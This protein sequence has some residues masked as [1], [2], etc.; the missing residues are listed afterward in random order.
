MI[1]VTGGAGFIGANLVKKLNQRGREDIIVV[2][3]MS[4]VNKVHNLADCTITDFLNKE[5]FLYFAGGARGQERIDVVFHQGACSDTMATDGHYVMQNN[6]SYSKAVLNFCQQHRIPLVYASSASVYGANQC[7]TEQKENEAPLNAYALSKLWFDQHLRTRLSQLTAP[8]MGLRYFNVY[9]YRE[10]HKGSMASVAH[11]FYQQFQRHQKVK[12]FKGSGGYDNGEQRRD[13]VFIDDVVDVNLHFWEHP[14][15]GI[16]NVG[17][18]QAHSFNDVAKAVVNHCVADNEM[19]LE[20]MHQQGLIEYVDFPQAL[21]GKY[22][23]Y[24]CADIKALRE[25]G[26]DKAFAT[27]E[28]AVPSYLQWISEHQEYYKI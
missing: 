16:Y 6:Y 5:E 3:D 20:Q 14:K 1:I 21:N 22:Q 15:S 10:Q 13:F 28:Q 7:F 19:S 18:G 24:T 9:G 27:P 4:D 11:H 2:D 12:L 26:F 23:H 17:S 8:V 25:S